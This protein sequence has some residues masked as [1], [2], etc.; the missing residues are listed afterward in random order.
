MQNLK[1]P[2]TRGILAVVAQDTAW[3]VGVAVMLFAL[4]TLFL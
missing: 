3:I 4:S 1:P 2:W